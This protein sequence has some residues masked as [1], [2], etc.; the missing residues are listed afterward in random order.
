MSEKRKHPRMGGRPSKLTREIQ[1]KIVAAIRVGNYAQVAA[2]YAGIG[3]TTFYAWLKRGEEE[4]QS[5][6]QEFREA[7]KRAESEAEVRTVALIHQHM[8]PSWQAGIGRI[9]GAALVGLREYLGPCGGPTCDRHRRA[10]IAP[11]WCPSSL[12]RGVL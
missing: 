12:R 3:E 7:V 1:D 8:Q 2:K 4:D 5:K 9:G 10:P 6:Y 11:R